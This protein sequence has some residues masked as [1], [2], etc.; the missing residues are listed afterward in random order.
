M[1]QGAPRKVSFTTGHGEPDINGTSDQDLAQAREALE[2]SNYEVQTINL[3]TTTAIPDDVTA[4]VID[5]P[6]TPLLDQEKAIVKSF[7]DRGGK[8]MFLAAP[9]RSVDLSDLVQP[10][11][12]AFADGFAIDAGQ[13]LQRQPFVPVISIYPELSPITRELDNGR[14]AVLAPLSTQVTVSQPLPEGVQVA[15]LMETTP[16]SW[17]ATSEKDINYRA[18][19]LKGPLT[20]GVAAT[21]PVKAP[22]GQS[23]P[24]AADTPSEPKTRIVAFGGADF[25]SNAAIGA[26]SNRQLFVN[27]VNWLTEEE[28]LINIRPEPPVDRTLTLTSTQANLL[29]YSSVLFLPLAI[30]AIG[31]FV[32]WSRR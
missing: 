29:I 11:G 23:S 18:G 4:I 17:L 24:S 13:S 12:L 32:W 7:L 20:L 30:A 14:Q 28:D 8:V 31:A 10:Y 21:A 19:D 22:T 6:I 25:A 16:D 3:A 26:L 2:A 9:K 1:A 5:A 27:A 15:R